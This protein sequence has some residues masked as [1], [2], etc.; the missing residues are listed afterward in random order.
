MK[1]RYKNFEMFF[2]TK[3]NWLQGVLYKSKEQAEEFFI[4]EHGQ[5]K[6][7]AYFLIRGLNYNFILCLD[8]YYGYYLRVRESNKPNPDPLAFMDSIELAYSYDKSND[9]LVVNNQEIK[10]PRS[11]FSF[12]IT[13]DQAFSILRKCTTLRKIKEAV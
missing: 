13:P 9:I 10:D 1:V 2:E 4:Y 3:S 7:Y 6:D 11:F 12:E 8:D 5:H